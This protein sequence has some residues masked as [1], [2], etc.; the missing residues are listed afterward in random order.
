[1]LVHPYAIKTVTSKILYSFL[2][3]VPSKIR[4][5]QFVEN[6]HNHAQNLLVFIL[7]LDPYII[8]AKYFALVQANGL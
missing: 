2:D 1:M 6:T 4:R 5:Q 8:S 7:V 3:T